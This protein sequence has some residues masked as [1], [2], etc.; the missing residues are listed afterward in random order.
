M[1]TA[2]QRNKVPLLLG[3]MLGTGVSLFMWAAGLFL[4]WLIVRS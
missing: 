2:D 3:F 4:F 1:M